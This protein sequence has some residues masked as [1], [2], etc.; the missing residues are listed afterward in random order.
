MQAAFSLWYNVDDRRQTIILAKNK[1]VVR[2]KSKSPKRNYK[3]SLFRDYFNNEE[4][5]RSLYVALSGNKAEAQEPL[6]INTLSGVFFNNI[7]ND[8][9]FMIGDRLIILIE[10]QSTVN[11]NMPLRFLFYIDELFKPLVGEHLEYK[12]ELFKLPVPEFYVFYNGKQNLENT[13][14]NLKDALKAKLRLW[15]CRSSCIILIMPAIMS[16]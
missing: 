2:M 11:P 4:R 16:F 6:T 12:V 10:H 9:S 8:I 7:K 14:L 15:T 1:G 13:T 5:L 3:D